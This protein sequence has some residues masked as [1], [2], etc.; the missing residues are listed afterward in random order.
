MNGRQTEVSGWLTFKHFV[1]F[2]LN[3]Q[4][5]PLFEGFVSFYVSPQIDYMLFVHKNLSWFLQNL[6]AESLQLNS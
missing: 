6:R 2:L 3:E 4:F 1:S 5:L